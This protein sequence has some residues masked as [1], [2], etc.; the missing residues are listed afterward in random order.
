LP[1]HVGLDK[2]GCTSRG[3]GRGKDPFLANQG[4]KGRKEKEDKNGESHHRKHRA[5]LVG[6]S[7]KKRKG[8]P[9]CL[10]KR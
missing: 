9:K 8:K 6:S 10:S 4:G 2:M 1:L 7:R 5:A 3:G